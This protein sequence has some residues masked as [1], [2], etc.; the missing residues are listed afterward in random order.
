MPTAPTILPRLSGLLATCLLLSLICI[1][2]GEALTVQ[3]VTAETAPVIKPETT[4]GLRA[5]FQTLDYSWMSFDEGV[6]P[7]ILEQIPEDINSSV[8]TIIKKKT[9]FMALLP[10]VLLA[11]Q[12]ISQERQE[13]Q[14][15]LDRH[16]TRTLETGDRE[17]ITEIAKRYGLRSRPL[18]D[19]R[20]RKQLFQRVDTVP[21]ALVLAQAA[22]ESAWGTSR[23]AQLGN[24][25]FGEWTFKPGTGLIPAGRPAGETYEVRV[26]ASIYQSIR[27]YLNNLNRN[28]AYRKLRGIRAELRKAEKRVTGAALAKGLIKYSQRGEEYIQEITVMIRQNNLE[29]VNLAKL[30][31][32]E[33]ENIVNIS[34]T[35]SGLFSTRNRLIGHSQAAR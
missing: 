26:F 10:M 14:Q 23:F 19:H 27:S 35:G 4:S 32:P 9:F 30:R 29:Q 21:P 31:Q 24:N 28:G 7:I 12:E 33:E 18:T 34:I 20:T 6:P 17:H 11:N 16:K 15:I 25:L 2:F 5:F 13:I 3:Q 1:P 22:N 8:S